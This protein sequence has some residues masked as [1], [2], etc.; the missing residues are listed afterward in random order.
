[1]A[2]RYKLPKKRARCVVQ[3]DDRAII[4]EMY[5]SPYFFAKETGPCNMSPPPNHPKVSQLPP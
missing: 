1:M 5:F 3:H 2:M 4:G